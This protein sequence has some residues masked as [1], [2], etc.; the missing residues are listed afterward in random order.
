MD[1]FIPLI[2]AQAHAGFIE[3][4]DEKNSFEVSNWYRIPGFNPEIEQNLFEVTGERVCHLHCFQ[5]I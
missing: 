1:G 5:E 4:F 3:N 2:R